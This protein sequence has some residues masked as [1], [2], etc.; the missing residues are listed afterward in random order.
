[1]KIEFDVKCKD[2][3]NDL[4][5]NIKKY[6]VRKKLNWISIPFYVEKL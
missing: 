4:V 2:Y 3:L 1:M 6:Q 5:K